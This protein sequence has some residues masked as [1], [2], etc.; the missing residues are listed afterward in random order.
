[1]SASTKKTGTGSE[2]ASDIT[3]TDYLEGIREGFLERN[4]AVANFDFFNLIVKDE[5]GNERG[6][7]DLKFTMKETMVLDSLFPTTSAFVQHSETV[8]GGQQLFFE[9]TASTG[10][11]ITNMK[12]AKRGGK[13]KLEQK[14]EF[15]NY[16][17]DKGIVG[18]NDLVVFVYNGS[19][20]ATVKSTFDKLRMFRGAV[21]HFRRQAVS[22][23][24][25]EEL[26]AK[27]HSAELSS[28]VVGDVLAGFKVLIYRDQWVVG[29]C[30]G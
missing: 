25:A 7:I 12:S 3:G 29:S 1:M 19:D 27:D 8:E 30:V 14:V 13:T 10:Q 18:A 26:L 4:A 5:S 6:D 23:W 21:I 22:S 17:L 9:V 11:I 15:Y 16:L 28:D 2:S 20:P 24:K